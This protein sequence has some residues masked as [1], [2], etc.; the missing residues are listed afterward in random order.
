MRHRTVGSLSCS[1]GKTP[2]A[3]T[4]RRAEPQQQYYIPSTMRCP[5]II[6]PNI[7]I[8]L[9]RYKCDMHKFYQSNWYQLIDSM[10]FP[11]FVIMQR[12]QQIRLLW[13]LTDAFWLSCARISRKLKRKQILNVLQV[14]SVNKDGCLNSRYFLQNCH[15]YIY[16]PQKSFASFTLYSL[17]LKF[18]VCNFAKREEK[19]MKQ[20]RNLVWVCGNKTTNFWIHLTIILEIPKI[21]ISQNFAKC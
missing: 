18:W 14:Q 12:R 13:P 19:C 1:Q 21:H 16:T 7:F 10:S 11:K 20:Y 5:W 4:D 15:L 17:Y 3:H 9:K 6:S 8:Y 2:D